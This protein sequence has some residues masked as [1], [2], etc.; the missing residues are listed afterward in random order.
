MK[1]NATSTIAPN[2]FFKVKKIYAAPTKQMHIN[3]KI[4]AETNISNEYFVAFLKKTTPFCIICELFYHSMFENS[5][6]CSQKEYEILEN[7]KD[8][9]L[10]KSQS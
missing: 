2:V 6:F 5:W 8:Q 1:P 10:K 4:I 9:L 7:K 3:G